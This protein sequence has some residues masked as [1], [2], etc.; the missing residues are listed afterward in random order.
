MK[1]APA[2]GNDQRPGDKVVYARKRVTDG[3]RKVARKKGPEMMRE[4]KL[5]DVG[6][7]IFTVMTQLANQHG[8]INLSQGFPDFDPHPRLVE[9]VSQ[10]MS[11]GFNQYAPMQGVMALRQQLSDKVQRIYG[12]RYDPE[13][14]I[15]ITA[16]ATEALFAAITASIRPGEEAIVFEPAYDAYLPALSLSGGIPVFVPLS[17]PDFAIDWNAVADAVTSKTRL[18]ILNSPHNPT[19]AVLGGADI[20]ALCQISRRHD[21]L[22]VADEVYEHI[23]FDGKTHR[24]MAMEPALA[25]RSFVIGSFGKTYHATGWKIGY[26]LAP[27]RLSREFQKIHQFLTFSVNTPVQIAYARYLAEDCSYRDLAGFYQRKRDLFRDQVKPSRFTALNCAGTYFQLLDY[28]SMADTPDTEMAR[29]LTQTHGVAAIPISVFY[30]D[31]RDH[32][33]LRFCFAKN[34][35]TLKEAGGRLCRI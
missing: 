32:R 34:D 10:A 29:L 33:L 31:R 3:K 20:E 27:A 21:L 11:A 35:Q 1:A 22:I 30:H 25:A 7:T 9:W 17:P 16:G 2:L 14:E 19:G 12:R 23:V 4:S 24:S 6:V 26:C 13:T 18:M 28:R 8:A 15:T 5:P